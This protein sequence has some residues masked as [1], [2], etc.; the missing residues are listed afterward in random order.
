MPSLFLWADPPSPDQVVWE[1]KVDGIDYG[2]VPVPGVYPPFK[3]VL[4]RKN[5]LSRIILS[6]GEI[7]FFAEPGRIGGIFI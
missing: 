6:T 4:I 1:D 5:S 2:A 7:W 3:S